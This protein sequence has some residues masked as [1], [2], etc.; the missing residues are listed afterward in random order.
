M[1]RRGINLQAPWEERGL[2][3]IAAEANGIG[4]CLWDFGTD[5]RRLRRRRPRVARAAARRALA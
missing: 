3:A 2:D 1:L 5:F 4:W